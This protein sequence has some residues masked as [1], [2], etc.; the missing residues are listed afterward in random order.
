MVEALENGFYLRLLE[1]DFAE[2]YGVGIA[3]ISPRQIPA[4]ISLVPTVKAFVKIRGC[5]GLTFHRANAWLHVQSTMS[6]A[7]AKSPVQMSILH[8]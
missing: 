5:F 3:R 7:Q 2:I 8:R 1:H 4:P 6:S